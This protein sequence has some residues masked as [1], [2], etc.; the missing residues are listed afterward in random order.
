MRLLMSPKKKGGGIPKVLDA[1]S[2]T[3]MKR[4]KDIDCTI[5]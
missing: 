4:F 5:L 1:Y 2:L 3:I